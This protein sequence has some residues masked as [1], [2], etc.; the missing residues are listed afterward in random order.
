[1]DKNILADFYLNKHY[2]SVQIG[3]RLGCSSSA[4]DYWLYKHSIKK[5]SI[6]EAMYVRKNPSGDPFKILPTD[7]IKSSFLHGLGL[8]LFWGEGN[9][10][11]LNSVRLG[12]SDPALIAKFIE[13]LKGAYDIDIDKLRF[14][15]QVFNDSNAKKCLEFWSSYLNVPEGSFQKV[16]VTSIRGKGS[17]KNKSEHGVLTVYFCNKRLR[18]IICGS[19]EKLRNA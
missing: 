13:F 19:I 8:G 18:D 15:L 12:N 4:I 9:K 11:D 6:S 16:V 10:R 2:S 3:Q 14:G 17:Y 1:M 7:S 5:R